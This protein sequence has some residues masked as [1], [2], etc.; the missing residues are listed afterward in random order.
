MSHHALHRQTLHCAISVFSVSLWL[1]FLGKESPQ[2]HRELRD[3]TEK[4]PN[5][6]ETSWLLHQPSSTRSF[7][8]QISPSLFPGNRLTRASTRSGRK[9]RA[10]TPVLIR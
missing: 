4:I 2:R 7:I 6:G 1:L 3:R 10:I 5:R 8:I 9:S